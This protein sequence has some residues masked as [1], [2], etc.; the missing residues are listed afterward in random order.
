MGAWVA[1]SLE[2][3]E[4]GETVDLLADGGRFSIIFSGTDTGGTFTNESTFLGRE[5]SDSGSWSMDGNTFTLD[6]GSD[7]QVCT[8]TP[9]NGTTTIRC[10][11]DDG[12]AVV[13]FLARTAQGYASLFEA[14]LWAAAED[15]TP[16]RA[17]IAS[18]SIFLA[19]QR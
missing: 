16:P 19:P 8:I 9:P 11:G 6:D 15:E 4:G 1:T 5:R 12:T 18:S 13:M 2:A 17:G 7:V 14:A 3:S 10:E